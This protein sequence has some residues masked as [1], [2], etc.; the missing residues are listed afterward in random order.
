MLPLQDILGTLNK[1]I[2]KG[3]NAR[4]LED[5][6]QISGWSRFHF[7][8]HFKSITGETPK[9]YELRLRLERAAVLLQASTKT[10]IDIALETGFS[11]MKCSRAHFAGNSN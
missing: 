3:A 7:H 1:S 5:L 11:S 2:F 6:A 4:S 9:Q 8:R 10:I